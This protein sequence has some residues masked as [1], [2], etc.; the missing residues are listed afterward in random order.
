MDNSPFSGSES[1]IDSATETFCRAFTRDR[2]FRGA[3]ARAIAHGSVPQGVDPHDPRVVAIRR[4]CRD[5][6]E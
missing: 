2:D 5:A 3:Y 4:R 6:E 1:I